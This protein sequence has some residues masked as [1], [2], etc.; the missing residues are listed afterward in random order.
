MVDTNRTLSYGLG[1]PQK[2]GLTG[3]QNDMFPSVT[4]AQGFV[5]YGDSVNYRNTETTYAAQDSLMLIRGKHAFK[6]GFEYQRH[7]DTD[8]TQST[9]AGL[10]SFSNLE[11]A[12][13]G[14]GATGN[15]IA[16]FLLGEV[17]SANATFFNTELGPVWHYYAAYLQDDFKM[18]PK[19]TLN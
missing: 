1:W 5:R 15:A 6:V 10:F 9:G 18:S 19:L 12:L 16:S 13:P 2:L 8:N 17:D 11:T 7:V 14:R 3:V 4:F